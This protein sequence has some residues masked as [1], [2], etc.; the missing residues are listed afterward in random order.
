MD[1]RRLLAAHAAA[2]EFYRARLPGHLP[3]LAYLHSRGVSEAV[4]HRPPWTVGYAPGG[5]TELRAALHA[6]GFLD[7]ELLAA[8]LATTARTGT[9]IDAFRD[10]VMFP[11]RRRD[12]L[13]VGFTGRDLSGRP[14]TP[15]YRNTITTAVYR[16]KHL[17]FGL[18]E[19]LPGDRPPGAVLLVEG[20]TDVLAVACLRRWLPD[21]PYV[22][23]SPCGTALT[24][25][26]VTL[27]RDTVTPGVPM[28]VAF[29]SDPAGEVAA[30]RAYRLLRDWAGPV[31]AL[32]LPSGTDPAGL[33]ARFRH[34]AVALMERARLPLAQVVVDH[35]LDR[36]RL[37]E[38]EGRVTALRAAAPLVAEVAERDTRQAATLSAHLSA[39]LSL[40]PLTVFEAVYPAQ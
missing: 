38:A 12:G 20:P 22:A 37:D 16:K 17:L 7:A 1:P 34:G 14:E 35:R 26:Q 4:A 32:A 13:V 19:Q 36:F 27:L 3:A 8:G 25:E 31:D 10:R 40:D 21:A 18:A 6:D 15:K 33:V 11:V 23:V 2:A 9:V 28:V 29:D 39:R 5:W 30:D 24:A